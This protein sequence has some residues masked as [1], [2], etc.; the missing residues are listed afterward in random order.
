MDKSKEIFILDK[1]PKIFGETTIDKL[2]E[3][4]FHGQKEDDKDKKD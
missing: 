2:I 4:G 3:I 1:S